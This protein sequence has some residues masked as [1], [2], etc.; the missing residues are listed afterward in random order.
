MAN[1]D[2]IFN[3]DKYFDNFLKNDPN[4]TEAEIKNDIEKVYSQYPFS[5][6]D[7]N[8][9]FSEKYQKIKEQIK[10]KLEAFNVVKEELQITEKTTNLQG[11]PLYIYEL[12]VF[13]QE[14]I[15]KLNK[16]LEVE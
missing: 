3:F 14:N 16:G 5:N 9:F 13:G 10:N 4:S 6:N 1:A 8:D 11:N 12:L 2:Q 7:G 15:D